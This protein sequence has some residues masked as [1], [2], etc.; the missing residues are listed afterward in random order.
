MACGSTD[1]KFALLAG[2]HA[3]EQ[4]FSSPRACFVADQA[5]MGPVWRQHGQLEPAGVSRAAARTRA[6][7]ACSGP[8]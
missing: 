4:N 5:V 3:A 2:A 7:P 6:E 1:D 8:L